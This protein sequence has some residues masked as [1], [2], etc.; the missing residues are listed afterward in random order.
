MLA[1]SI[2][3][4]PIHLNKDKASIMDIDSSKDAFDTLLK[5]FANE[6]KEDLTEQ[7]T[8]FKF[9]DQVLTDVLGWSRKD[10]KTEPYVESGYIDYLIHSDGR[11]R[12]VVEAKKASRLLIDSVYPKMRSYKLNG[13]ALQSAQDGLKQARQY[14]GDTGVSFAALTTGFEWIG[15]FAV[16]IDG[17]SPG[18]GK[19]IVFPNFDSIIESFAIFYELF[20]K[21]GI[22]NQLNRV[23]MHEAEGLNVSTMVK[24]YQVVDKSNICM[25]RKSKLATDM[26]R[27][28]AEFF[29]AMSGE[30]DPEMLAKCFVESKESKQADA[31]LD[32]IAR[33]LIN[34]I[35]IVSPSQGEELQ[36]QIRSAVESRRGEF[37]LIIGNKG[38]GK[39]TF[40]D[41]FF[42]LVLDRAL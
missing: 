23:H 3:S 33:N 38:A 22:L 16:R 6:K 30:N 8:R 42:R 28:F 5:E 24:L 32:K 29:G 20:S 11:N 14:C 1:C 2:N 25:L 34:Q 18:E 13:P 12:F 40:I 7:D 17:K 31:N 35:N 4:S 26:D 9:I 21:E 27:I 15:F 19:A 36:E 41:R 37:V 39:S 10:I